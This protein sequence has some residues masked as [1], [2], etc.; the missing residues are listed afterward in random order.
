MKFSPVSVVSTDEDHD[1]MNK[2]LASA[3]KV[4][5]IFGEFSE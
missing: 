5:G 4:C 1:F 2:A 3:A